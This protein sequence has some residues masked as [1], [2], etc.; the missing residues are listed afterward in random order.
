[1]LPVR[2]ASRLLNERV[3]RPLCFAVIAYWEARKVEVESVIQQ[4]NVT[5]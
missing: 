4:M 2:T 3:N 5:E 1:M